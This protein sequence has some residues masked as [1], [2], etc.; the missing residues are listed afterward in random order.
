M[1]LKDWF[2]KK[3]KVDPVESAPPAAYAG[4]FPTYEDAIEDEMFVQSKKALKISNEKPFGWEYLLFAQSIKDCYEYLKQFRQQ[5]EGNPFV[6]RIG[7]DSEGSR[8]LD[9][10][11]GLLSNFDLETE[12]FNSKLAIVLRQY[13][14]AMGDDGEDGDEDAIPEVAI[15]FMD[16]YISYLGFYNDICTV[17]A[18][19]GLEELHALLKQMA[20]S[21][22]KC[23]EKLYEDIYSKY[24][25]VVAHPETADENSLSF[26]FTIKFDEN[27][28]KRING[29]LTSK[30]YADLLTTATVHRNC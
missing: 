1:A 26:D 14:E 15:R 21:L 12:R 6:K 23:C 11:Q 8:Y 20:D 22:L 2:S 27:T 3:K 4:R 7:N 13:N 30:K 18:P 28:S 19:S 24:T 16:P 29:I 25:Y 10:F 17:K 9:Y 5:N